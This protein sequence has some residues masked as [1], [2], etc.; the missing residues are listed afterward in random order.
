GYSLNASNHTDNFD[1]F[2]FKIN[3]VV[4]PRDCQTCHPVEVQQFSDSKKAHALGNIE[5]NPVFHTMVDSAV[6][7][8]EIKD[9]KLHALA[10]SD[11]TKS[12]SCYGCHGSRVEVIGTRKL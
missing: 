4:S 11:A 8:R 5:K 10:G 1:H 3:V 9:G 2:D 12:E 6:G 7:L